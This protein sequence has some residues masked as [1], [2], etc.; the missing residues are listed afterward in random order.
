MAQAYRLR[1]QAR[2]YTGFV[3]ANIPGC[4]AN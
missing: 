2:S 4:A 1:G 3:S